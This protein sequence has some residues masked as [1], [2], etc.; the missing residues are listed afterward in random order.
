MI[1][2]VAHCFISPENKFKEFEFYVVAGANVALG[3]SYVFK[4]RVEKIYIPKKFVMPKP[5]V[6]PRSHIF[7]DIAI[8]QVNNL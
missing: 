1:L 3:S 6:K 8:L 7:G 4:Q 5:G 2:T